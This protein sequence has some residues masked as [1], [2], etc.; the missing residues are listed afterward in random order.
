MDGQ[1]NLYFFQ[2]CASESGPSVNMEA[3]PAGNRKRHRTNKLMNDDHTVCSSKQHPLEIVSNQCFQSEYC[4]YCHGFLSLWASKHRCRE[5]ILSLKQRRAPGHSASL[6]RAI[7]IFVIQSDPRFHFSM[8]HYQQLRSW[9][10][11]LP[12]IL[13][14]VTMGVFTFAAKSSTVSF[15]N[16]CFIKTFGNDVLR[17]NTCKAHVL[18][19]KVCLGF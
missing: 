3:S 18:I 13:K 2:W 19:Y 5:Q 8:Q 7:C 1:L 14:S 15:Q 10:G 6:C 11:V 9:F 4:A 17:G 16:Q 12:I